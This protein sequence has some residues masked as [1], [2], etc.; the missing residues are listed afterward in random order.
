MYV[1]AGFTHVTATPHCLPG[2]PQVPDPQFILIKIGTIINGTIT[3]KK[4]TFVQ[5]ID[6]WAIKL[7]TKNSGVT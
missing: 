2:T 7:F 3:Q 4:V 5:N 6:N 1:D